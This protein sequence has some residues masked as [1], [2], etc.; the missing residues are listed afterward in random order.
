MRTSVLLFEW[1]T[2]DGWRGA[3]VS[4]VDVTAAARLALDTRVTLPGRIGPIPLE[5]TFARSSRTLG[6]RVPPHVTVIE[7]PQRDQPPGPDAA[8][9]AVLACLDFARQLEEADAAAR[10]AALHN[11]TVGRGANVLPAAVKRAASAG[12]DVRFALE[13]WIALAATT[14]IRAAI[15]PAVG[16]PVLGKPGEESPRQG[17]PSEAA[18]VVADALQ[19][20][21]RE[22]TAEYTAERG[23]FLTPGFGDV[24]L[25]GLGAEV[26]PIARYTIGTTAKRTGVRLTIRHAWLPRG[27][28]SI[29]V[30]A[31]PEPAPPAP[32]GAA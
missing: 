17:I 10:A 15:P 7:I 23:A 19:E 9:A 14:R 32:P 13:A 25:P 30:I 5:D 21:A 11:V 27:E 6:A 20:L 1:P 22:L 28:V 3:E 26:G 2:G 29:V 4:I 12:R 18:Y 31:E 16:Y 24:P 8:S